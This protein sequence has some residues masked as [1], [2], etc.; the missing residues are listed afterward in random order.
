MALYGFVGNSPTDKTDTLGLLDLSYIQ[1]V[2]EITDKAI[3]RT[4]C[5]CEKK[6]IPY[7]DVGFTWTISGKTI[8]AELTTKTHGC[9]FS[10]LSIWWWDCVGAQAEAPWWTLI[11]G[12]AWQNY[13]WHKNGRTMTKTHEGSSSSGHFDASHWDWT[14]GVIYTKCGED[15]YLHA[16]W[17]E[18]NDVNFEWDGKSKSWTMP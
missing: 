12:D 16:A 4:R 5:C 10:I 18:A 15:G 17:Q 14:A 2:V 6:P 7:V 9:V 3:S 1:G 11:W 8:A 13:G